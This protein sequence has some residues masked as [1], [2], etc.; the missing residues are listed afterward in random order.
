MSIAFLS[1]AACTAP[2]TDFGSFGVFAVFRATGVLTARFV[3]VIAM[4]IVFRSVEV[5]RGDV[6][7]H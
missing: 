6:P 3:F 4:Q 2:A 5:M 7:R 1:S